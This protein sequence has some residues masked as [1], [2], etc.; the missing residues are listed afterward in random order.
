MPL[1]LVIGYVWPEPA[2]SAAGWRMLSLLQMFVQANWRVIFASSAEPGIQPA[3]LAALG[4]ETAV[5]ELNNDSFAKQLAGWQPT[6]VMFDRFM[7]EEQYGWWVD[8]VCPQALKI[9]DSEDLHCLRHARAAAFRQQRAV[10]PADLTNELALREIAAILRC[11]LTLTI[12]SAEL[13]LLT[14]FY[15]VPATQLLYCPFMLANRDIQPGECFANRQH[16]SFIGNFRHEP[17]WQTVLRLHRLWPELRLQLPAGTELHIYGA[18]P[19]PKATALAMPKQGFHIKGWASQAQTA[20]STYR[21]L[22][23][24]IPFGAGLKGKIVE[25]ALFGC[26]VVTSEYGA[27]GFAEPPDWG[28]FPGLVASDDQSFCQA[29]SRLYQDETLWLSTR[30]NA[31]DWL[32]QF[33]QER[34]ATDVMMIVHQTL[35]DLAV[36]RQRH[37][38]GQMLKYHHHRSTKFMGQ[39]ITAKNALARVQSARLPENN[40]ATDATAAVLVQSSNESHEGKH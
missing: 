8:D 9:L 18:Y 21:V 30:A 33:A 11:D 32:E 35:A 5:I 27:E 25:A 38:T 26:P 28:G 17:N 3:D 10:M 36:H 16:V 31:V 37:F 22:A 20:F 1:L 13:A 39:W 24:P 14:D 6:A 7:L 15:Q 2:S 40:G 29:V 19:P 34:V 23:A 4:I 12:S